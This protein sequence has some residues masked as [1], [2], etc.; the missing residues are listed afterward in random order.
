M[1][2]RTVKVTSKGQM[3]LPVDVLRSMNARKGTELVLV[4]EGDRILLTKA[5]A[6]G[7]RVVDDL[8]GWEA[9]G[10]SAFQDVWDNDADAVWDD[11]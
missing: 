2:V 1:L 11:A 8:G 3:S 4:Q 7:K 5:S 10:A 9:L 6:V